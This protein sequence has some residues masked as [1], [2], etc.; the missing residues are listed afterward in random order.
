MIDCCDFCTSQAESDAHWAR[1]A[2]RYGKDLYGEPVKLPRGWELVPFRT[3]IPQLHREFIHDPLATRG[4]WAFERCGHSTMTPM[5][6][7]PSGFTL[8]YARIVK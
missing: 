7:R 6:A 5:T 3:P 4:L 1:W 2:E 8:A